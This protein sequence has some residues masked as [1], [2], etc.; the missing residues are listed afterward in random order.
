MAWREI[1]HNFFIN[2]YNMEMNVDTDD[3]SSWYTTH[4]NFLVGGEWGMKSDEGGHS[5]WQH[6]NLNAYAT[7]PAVFLMNSQAKGYEDKYENNTIIQLA[8]PVVGSPGGA[9]SYAINVTNNRVYTQSGIASKCLG[10]P[11]VTTE[12][13]GNTV[14]ELPADDEVIRWAK[15]LLGMNP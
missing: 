15:E 5:N 6:N 3:G 1:S 2:N 14:S 10:G 11:S 9:C 8:G 4:H 13:I 7:G 12:G